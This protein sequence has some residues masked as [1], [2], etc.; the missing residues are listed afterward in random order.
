MRSEEFGIPGG[1]P[2]GLRSQ[3]RLQGLSYLSW[4]L[5]AEEDSLQIKESWVFTVGVGNPAEGIRLH[6]CP[7]SSFSLSFP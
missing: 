6:E 5:K 2:K 4:V 3:G 1:G 7:L